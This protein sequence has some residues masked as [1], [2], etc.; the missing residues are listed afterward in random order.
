MFFRWIYTIFSIHNLRNHWWEQ[1]EIENPIKEINPGDNYE[2]LLPFIGIAT[3]I[4]DHETL[5]LWNLVS[6]LYM[7]ISP[8]QRNRP[9]RN[10]NLSDPNETQNPEPSTIANNQEDSMVFPPIANLTI[11]TNTHGMQTGNL[12]PHLPSASELGS[13][14][15]FVE[16]DDDH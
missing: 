5:E 12:Q 4:E 3:I 10:L 7:T 1:Y 14:L 16:S 8:N 9:R 13:S 11:T 15:G 6:N 2:Y